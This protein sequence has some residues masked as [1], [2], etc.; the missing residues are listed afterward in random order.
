M[1]KTDKVNMKER[2]FII[3]SITGVAAVILFYHPI[4]PIHL[5]IGGMTG[6]WCG[7]AAYYLNY[8]LFTAIYKAIITGHQA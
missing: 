7:L 8:G 2:L 4:V 5:V 6:A 3:G 1:G